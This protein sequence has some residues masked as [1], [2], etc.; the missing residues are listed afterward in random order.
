MKKRDFI[1]HLKKQMRMVEIE[2]IKQMAERLKNVKDV[3]NIEKAEFFGIVKQHEEVLKVYRN[4]ISLAERLEDVKCPH[5]LP[6]GTIEG[7]AKSL[8]HALTR[9]R[10]FLHSNLCDPEKANADGMRDLVDAWLGSHK[11]F[12]EKYNALIGKKSEA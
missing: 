1:E 6:D 3:K 9:Y 5:Y 4:I 10:N 7:D 11:M 12:S 8:E 2:V